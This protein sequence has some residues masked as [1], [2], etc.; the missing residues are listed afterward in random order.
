MSFST[1]ALMEPLAQARGISVARLLGLENKPADLVIRN[2]TKISQ[3]EKIA[4]AQEDLCSIS[5]TAM[6]LLLFAALIGIVRLLGQKDVYLQR[7]YGDGAR[8]SLASLAQEL[9]S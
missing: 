8:Y 6:T 5:R 2:I 7:L 9:M 1:P 3:S 4:S